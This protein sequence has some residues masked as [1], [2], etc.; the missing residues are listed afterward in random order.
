MCSHV[1]GGGGLTQIALSKAFGSCFWEKTW[2]RLTFEAVLKM[3]LFLAP[4]LD[5][6]REY[7]VLGHHA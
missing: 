7:F 1:Q 4:S 3:T 2:R 6:S 5:L